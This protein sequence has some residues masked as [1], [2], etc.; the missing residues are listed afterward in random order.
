[1]L[2]RPLM[3]RRE[4]RQRGANAWEVKLAGGRCRSPVLIHPK[5]NIWTKALHIYFFFGG[6]FKMLRNSRTVHEFLPENEVVFFLLWNI[7]HKQQ[8]IDGSAHLFSFRTCREKYS[9]SY[10]ANMYQGKKARLYTAI[11]SCI[12]TY[13]YINIYI[14]RSS[15]KWSYYYYTLLLFPCPASWEVHVF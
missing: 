12:Y 13:T 8:F 3:E 9:A 7:A 1:M 6:G 14:Y 10:C 5:K 2:R 11:F 4:K 15:C